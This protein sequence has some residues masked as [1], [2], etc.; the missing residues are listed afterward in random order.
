MWFTE[1]KVDD[2][3]NNQ[4]NDEAIWTIDENWVPYKNGIDPWKVQAGS[5]TNGGSQY[6]PY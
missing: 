3:M 5:D 4:L 1:V 2:L 6:L